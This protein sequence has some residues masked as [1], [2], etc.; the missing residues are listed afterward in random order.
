M[1][2]ACDVRHGRAGERAR[3]RESVRLCSGLSVAFDST[4]VP[5]GTGKA[6]V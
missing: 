6:T 1:R 3:E 2:G 5:H 4:S